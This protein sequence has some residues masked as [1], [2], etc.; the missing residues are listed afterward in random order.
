ML[1]LENGFA[2]PPFAVSGDIYL[3]NEFFAVFK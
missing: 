3:T 1:Y 2:I